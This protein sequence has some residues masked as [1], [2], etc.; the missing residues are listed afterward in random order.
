VASPSGDEEL[1]YIWPDDGLPVT[2]AFVKNQ[3]KYG[4]PVDQSTLA[5]RAQVRVGH[6][7]C[8]WKVG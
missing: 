1:K 6:L 7:N 8:I 2:P 3:L 4:K 5:R